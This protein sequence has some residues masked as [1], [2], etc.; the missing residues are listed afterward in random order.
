MKGVT[1]IPTGS[2]HAKKTKMKDGQ[3][4]QLDQIFQTEEEAIA[5]MTDFMKDPTT[6]TEVR[7]CQCSACSFHEIITQIIT[8]I[9]GRR[10][11]HYGRN[12]ALSKF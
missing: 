6:C 1:Q 8:R 12:G 4:Y 11:F 7:R 9:S 10:Q 2:W 5:A 3:Q